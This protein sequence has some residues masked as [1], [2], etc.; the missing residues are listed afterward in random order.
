MREYSVVAYYYQEGESTEN[1]PHKFTE[2]VPASGAEGA[3]LWTENHL[4][5][6][7]GVTLTGD[8][9]VYPPGKDEPELFPV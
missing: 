1:D 6:E 5:T 9:E 4:R 7:V 2:R 3:A 8:V